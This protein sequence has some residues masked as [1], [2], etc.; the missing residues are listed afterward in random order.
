MDT[1]NFWISV[2]EVARIVA[3]KSLNTGVASSSALFSDSSHF[4]HT[5]VLHSSLFPKTSRALTAAEGSI[6]ASTP[7]VSPVGAIPEKGEEMGLVSCV[8]LMF[9]VLPTARPTCAS[10]ACA[11]TASCC[12]I[13]LPPVAPALSL[14]EGG[15]S[16]GGVWSGVS[17]LCSAA[18]VPPVGISGRVSGLFLTPKSLFVFVSNPGIPDGVSGGAF[19]SS[20]VPLKLP[21][22]TDSVL[23]LSPDH[24]LL[25]IVSLKL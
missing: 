12:L 23:Y 18:P 8:S 17:E 9:A 19:F 20:T 2:S 13:V 24:D 7:A 21:L 14:R 11:L 1:P 4:P 16:N 10:C 15:D 22:F 25:G 3:R 5:A 6:G